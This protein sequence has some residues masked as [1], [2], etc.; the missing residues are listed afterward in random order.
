MAD[1]KRHQVYVLQNQ[2]GEFYIGLS[3]NIALRLLQHNQGISKW[4]W[5]HR[6]WSMAWASELMSLSDARRLEAR[7]KR[8]KGG[9]GFQHLTGL[10]RL[11]GSG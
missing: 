6:P 8:Q 4:T 9:V 5:K 2:D 10:S 7:F 3:E 11:V 1:G